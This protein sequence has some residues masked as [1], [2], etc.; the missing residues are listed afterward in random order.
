MS[1][2]DRFRSFFLLLTGSGNDQSLLSP[3][4][5]P[6]W[7]TASSLR[8]SDLDSVSSGGRRVHRLERD[9][10]SSSSGFERWDCCGSSVHAQ[11]AQKEVGVARL[12]R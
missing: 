10:R 12:Q 6:Q 3:P 2:E 5:S 4:H 1:L 9:S 7:V 11:G 8:S